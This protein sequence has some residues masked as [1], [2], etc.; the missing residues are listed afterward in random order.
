M[1]GIPQIRPDAEEVLALNPIW[2]CWSG[3]ADAARVSCDAGLPLLDLPYDNTL[4][5]VRATLLLGD[6]LAPRVRAIALLAQMDRDAGAGAGGAAQA[7][8]R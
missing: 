5:D 7:I 1:G 8:R 4:A 2:S 6:R 3:G